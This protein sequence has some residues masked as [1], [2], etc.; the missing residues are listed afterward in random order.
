MTAEIRNKQR[1]TDRSVN[2]TDKK[3][4]INR[5]VIIVQPLQKESGDQAPLLRQHPLI[6]V[7]HQVSGRV[8][9]T[10][11]LPTTDG[12]TS[13]NHRRSLSSAYFK[14]LNNLCRILT[15]ILNTD[16]LR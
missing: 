16:V 5:P 10:R 14:R 4:S 13:D 7:G 2:L 8:Y 11:A 3:S 9:Y 12:N 6:Y 15:L 1:T